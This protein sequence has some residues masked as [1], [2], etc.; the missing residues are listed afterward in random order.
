MKSIGQQ[1]GVGLIGVLV[2]AVVFAVGITAVVQL[3]GT[4]LK[5]AALPMRAPSQ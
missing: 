1:R 3:Q 4:F 5:V 2:A